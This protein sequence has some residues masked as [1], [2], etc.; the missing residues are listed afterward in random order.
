[1]SLRDWGT[2]HCKIHVPLSDRNSA[3][4]HTAEAVNNSID[5]ISQRTDCFAFAAEGSLCLRVRVMQLN[6]DTHSTASRHVCLLPVCQCVNSSLHQ[7]DSD[8]S[9][10]TPDICLPLLN[11]VGSTHIS[12]TPAIGICDV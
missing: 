6:S 2:D 1:M 5:V 8:T 4:I 3:W 9:H 12:D 10:A 7:C 11:S